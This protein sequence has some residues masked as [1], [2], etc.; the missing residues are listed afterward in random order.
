MCSN[1]YGP[2][3]KTYWDGKLGIWPFTE[4]YEAKRGSVNRPRGTVCTR[5]IDTVNRD[6]YRTYLLQHVIPAIK[7]KWAKDERGK[8]ILI[9][10]D[11]A[12]PHVPPQDLDVVAAGP[13][14]GWNIRLICQPPNSPDLNVLN[15]GLFAS[16]Q[17]IQYRTPLRTVEDII[18]AVE[19]AYTELSTETMDNIFLTLQ[20][21]MLNTLQA[22]GGN[23]YKLPH[24]GKARLRNAGLLPDSLDCGVDVLDAALAVLKQAGRGSPSLFN[25]SLN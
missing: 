16:L 5:K 4:H 20:Q 21:C 1:R 22:S 18:Q 11:N 7:L 24:M 25:P 10:Q 23:G 3:R 6:V 15:I 14:D 19:A 13:A 9:Q 2:H 8:L 17:S 12:K